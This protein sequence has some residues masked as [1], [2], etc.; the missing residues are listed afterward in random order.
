MTWIERRQRWILI[1]G[2]LAADQ[3]PPTITVNGRY[4]SATVEVAM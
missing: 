4:G 1:V 2:R 3:V